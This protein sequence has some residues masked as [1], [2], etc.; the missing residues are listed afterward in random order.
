[1][2]KKRFKR[3]HKIKYCCCCGAV[4][5]G[6]IL[7]S[8]ACDSHECKSY[9]RMPDRPAEIPVVLNFYGSFQADLSA[10]TTLQQE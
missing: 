3:N 7:G 1:M 5:T 4:A 2:S 10:T 9:L 8:G 6:I